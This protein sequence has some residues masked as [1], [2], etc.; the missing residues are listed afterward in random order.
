MK[1][2]RFPMTFPALTYGI[3]TQSEEYCVVE[4][5][6]QERRIRFHDYHEIYAIPDPYEHLFYERLKSKSPN[7]IT[8]LL[9]E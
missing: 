5:D 9:I 2:A 3:K 4:Y 6:G 7:V 1:K 8:R